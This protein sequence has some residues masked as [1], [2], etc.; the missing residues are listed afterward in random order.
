MKNVMKHSKKG[1]LMVTMLATLLSFA[2]E[3]PFYTIEK[4]AKRTS[5]T[6]NFVK[7]GNLLSIK[8]VNGVILY[9]ELIQNSGTFTKAFDLTS[10][11]NGAYVYELDKDLEINVIPFLVTHGTVL[12]DKEKEETI[13]KPFTRVKG[14][15]VYVSKLELK[16]EP[17]KIEIYAIT[18]YGDE[19]L[20]SETIEGTT[21]IE[22]VYKF[23]GLS[24]GDYKIV[25][26]TAGREFVKMI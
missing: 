4:G 1:I 18:N 9:K 5:L 7:Q 10:L 15:I 14:N 8:D 20:M 23:K 22:R 25:Y 17:L 6:L 3:A 12:F 26:R 21:N 2:K 16:N 19:L 11:P 24:R 13:Y